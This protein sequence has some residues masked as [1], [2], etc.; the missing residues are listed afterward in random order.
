MP[1]VE[2]TDNTTGQAAL[3]AF[4]GLREQPYGVTPDPRFLYTTASHREALASLIYA[5]ETKRGFSAL[6]AQ[7]GMG[8]TTLLFHVLD[9]IKSTART[10]F[11][12]RPDGNS[13]DLLQSL[14]LDLGLEASPKDVPQM[15]ELLNSVLLED[16]H[17]GRH[18]VWVID[19]AQDLDNEVLES[20]RLF[21]NF[22][23][24]VSKLMHIVLAGQPGL[25]EKLASPELLQL[26]QR[27]SVLSHLEPL[28]T[29]ETSDY[30][31]HRARRAG[32]RNPNLFAPESRTLVAQ[33]S[34]GIPRNINNICFSCL[35]MA[36]AEGHREIDPG[37]VREVLEDHT[38]EVGKQATGKQAAN[39][40]PP[41]QAWPNAFPE[42][43][44]QYDFAEPPPARSRFWTSLALFAFFVLPLL[45]IVL[46]SNSRVGVLE[47]FLGP[48][49]EHIVSQ[50]TGYDPHMP[51]LPPSQAPA[52]QAPRPPMPLPV[53]ETRHSPAPETS[54]TDNPANAPEQPAPTAER[55]D[56]TSPTEPSAASPAP[57][58][59][60]VIY[61]RGGENLF[62]LALEY[63][64]KSNWTIVTK[65][66]SENPQIKDSFTVFR[67]RQRVVLPDLAPAYPW[68]AGS[69]GTKFSRLSH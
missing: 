21:S 24:P 20:V 22:E 18:F 27:V 41:T 25:A 46:E 38:F 10:A 49:T 30:I 54:L 19:E 59:P 56:L 13:R 3:L 52:L 62:E 45:L 64:G 44:P 8:K 65:I 53:S 7:P 23:T 15:H 11:L 48:A 66:R 5:I 26:R 69:G 57:T 35:S 68:R 29:R 58:G 47:A 32:C 28:S 55:P 51:D 17:A 4:F 40:S 60:R 36:F 61:T 31:Q 16:L 63:Y 1:T 37:I 9:K 6:V 34:L 42:L 12:F 67:E 2:C 39:P 14:L 43:L 33:A 50:I